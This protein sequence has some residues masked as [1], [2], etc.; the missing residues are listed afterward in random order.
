MPVPVREVFGGEQKRRAEPVRLHP[1]QLLVVPGDDD[2]G[3]RDVVPPQALGTVLGG[4]VMMVG[5]V[6]LALPI[7]VIGSNFATIY[8]K[9]V[10]DETD[11]VGADDEEDDDDDLD[12]LESE[13]EE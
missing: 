6:V 8:K 12:E 4:V 5:I 13:E 3:V 1:E 2:H 9:M 10:M 11:P 7:P